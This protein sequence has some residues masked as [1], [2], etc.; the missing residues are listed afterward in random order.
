VTD[1]TQGEEAVSAEDG[2]LPILHA[3]K[4]IATKG[5]IK[6]HFTGF[7]VLLAVCAFHV[8]IG[9]LFNLFETAPLGNLAP[10]TIPVE[11]VTEVPAEKTPPSPP[12]APAADAKPQ[13]ADKVADDAAAKAREKAEQEKA[14]QEK[15]EKEK[16]EQAKAE[17]EKAEKAQEKQQEK[18][19]EKTPETPPQP[20]AAAPEPPKPA[21]EPPKSAPEPPKPA[22][23]PPKP[24]PEPPKPAPEPPKPE[25][26]KA[27]LQKSAK[28]DARKPA[29]APK[30][31]SAN[32]SK[33]A[34]RQ[35][36]EPPQAQ[37]V[38]RSDQPKQ[39]VNAALPLTP[40]SPQLLSPLP[41]NTPPPGEFRPIVGV[42]TSEDGEDTYSYQTIVFSRLELAK[43]SLKQSLETAWLR[44]AR[45]AAGIGFTLDK[46]GNVLDV[47]LLVSSGNPDVDEQ[48]VALV[49]HAEPFPP[50]PTGEQTRIIAV[51]TFDEDTK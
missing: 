2:G 5:S 22:P 23:E 15:A 10:E 31:S 29:P 39:T 34:S 11:L 19:Q 6:G 35:Q 1:I 7:A 9:A 4:D 41:Y 32:R 37:T 50:S 25:A 36:Q 51:V 13:G 30:T 27:D 46:T 12:K 40:F 43:Q 21:P 3:T 24:A 33:Q 44:G 16:A 42:P 14:E 47:E 18:P 45:G 8:G 28:A 20:P 49:R 26:Q 38:P 17:K 48:S